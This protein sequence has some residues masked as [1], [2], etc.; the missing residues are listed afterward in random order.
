MNENEIK[1]MLKQYLLVEY[2]MSKDYE[3]S[4]MWKNVT[5]TK[6]S[7]YIPDRVIKLSDKQI[8]KYTNVILINKGRKKQL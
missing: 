5:S 1:N 8:L 7:M 3:S 2:V 4:P 6:F